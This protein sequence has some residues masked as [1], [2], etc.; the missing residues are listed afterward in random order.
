MPVTGNAD[1]RVP[2]LTEQR[3][4]RL[5]KRMDA[6][7]DKVRRASARLEESVDVLTRLVRVVKA[8]NE[9]MNRSF[10]RLGQRMDRLSR[11]VTEGRT[12]DLRR[13]ATIE[14]RL[15]AL[16]RQGS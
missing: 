16:E 10:A 4:R 13:L 1:K 14:R 12:A 5:E 3:L 8:E 9:K 11:A 15:E 6:L 7:E 2:R